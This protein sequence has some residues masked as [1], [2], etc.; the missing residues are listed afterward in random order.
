VSNK[1]RLLGPKIFW[2]YGE[3]QWMFFFF[4]VFVS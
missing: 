2:L 1:G 3:A 4:L